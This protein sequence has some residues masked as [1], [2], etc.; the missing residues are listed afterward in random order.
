MFLLS[1]KI[2]CHYHYH[3]HR[4][5]RCGRSQQDRRPV[6]HLFLFLL[7]FTFLFAKRAGIFLYYS[8][9]HAWR[10][11]LYPC[12]SGIGNWEWDP[13]CDPRTTEFCVGYRACL[14]WVLARKHL[15]GMRWK[16]VWS[17]GMQY[18]SSA[19]FSS[20]LPTCFLLF[21]LP[22]LC[23]P[24]W[25]YRPVFLYFFGP[26]RDGKGRMGWPHRG[27]GVYCTACV[28]GRAWHGLLPYKPLFL[29]HKVF[30]IT[31]RKSPKG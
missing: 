7:F 19:F 24:T 26:D 14:A 6:N 3:H 4:R 27:L 16:I 1:S 10:L 22:L 5:R 15:A 12:G 29:F 13:L 18:L 11:L 28:L 23:G 9:T 30:L 21:F 8:S 20:S 17:R 2:C 31:A 25:C